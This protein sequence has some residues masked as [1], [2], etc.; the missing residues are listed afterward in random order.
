MQNRPQQRIQQRFSRLALTLAC[1]ALLGACAGMDAQEC[2]DTDW[3]YLGQLD[4]MDGKL[5]IT[6]R[7]KR[8]FNTCKDN[9]VKMDVRAYQQGWMRGLKDFCTPESGKA[10]GEAGRKYQYGYCPAQVEPAFMQGYGPV[11]DRIEVQE[12]MAQLERRIDMKKKELREARSAKNS[13]SHIA[14]VEKDLRDLNVEMLQLRF[15]LAQMQ[16]K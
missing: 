13:A 11:R 9:G 7:A 14:Y 16:A 2:K 15:K 4:A 6:T 5:D 10:F 1:S 12:E 3:A 8:H